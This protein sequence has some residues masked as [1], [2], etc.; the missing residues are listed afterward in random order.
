MPI[1]CVKS[2]KIYTGQKKFT[3]AP[4]VALV[5]NIRYDLEKSSSFD[6]MSFSCIIST[7]NPKGA[8]GDFVRI[9]HRSHLSRI[10]LRAELKC[11]S[12]AIMSQT[13]TFKQSRKAI[14]PERTKQSQREPERATAGAS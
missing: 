4:L 13:R 7:D 9:F 14:E 2:V 6:A 1:L 10:L 11:C 5:T 8:G 3:Q 12:D